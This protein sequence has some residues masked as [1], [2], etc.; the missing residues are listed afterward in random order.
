MGILKKSCGHLY[1]SGCSPSYCTA[2][3]H[4][5]VVLGPSPGRPNSAAASGHCTAPALWRTQRCAP[6]LMAVVRLISFIYT[7]HEFSPGSILNAHAPNC[8]AISYLGSESLCCLPPSGR[9]AGW[10]LS[11]W[12]CSFL[13]CKP[14]RAWP[15]LLSLPLQCSVPWFSLAAPLSPPSWQLTNLSLQPYPVSINLLSTS[16]RITPLPAQGQPGQNWAPDFS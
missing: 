11:R 1:T 12:C 9:P 4:Q 8:P 15:G 7:T 5:D 16:P 3:L 10:F 6:R 13:L 2:V 14:P